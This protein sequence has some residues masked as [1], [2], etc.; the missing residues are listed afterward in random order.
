[1]QQEPTGSNQSQQPVT[2]SNAA[3]RLVRH[4][5]KVWVG[6]Q[7]RNLRATSCSVFADIAPHLR[8]ALKGE[9]GKRGSERRGLGLLGSAMAAQLELEAVELLLSWMLGSCKP[10]EGSPMSSASYHAFRERW[11]PCLVGVV[12]ISNAHRQ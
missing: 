1:M 12:L 6:R 10:L 4:Q 7:A 8:P 11:G 9:G 2:Q 3:P 5:A